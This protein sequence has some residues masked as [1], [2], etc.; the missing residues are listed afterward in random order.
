MGGL[1][2][3]HEVSDCAFEGKFVGGGDDCMV[4]GPCTFCVIAWLE[5]GFN[6]ISDCV[7]GVNYFLLDDCWHGCCVWV[8]LSKVVLSKL[9]VE[10]AVDTIGSEIVI[11]EVN[12]VEGFAWW[13]IHLLLL[14]LLCGSDTF[15]RSMGWGECWSLMW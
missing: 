9:S 4:E 5:Q 11:C 13:E 12:E 6:M 14:G 2:D 8:I 15:C 1:D 3:V 7:M 10:V